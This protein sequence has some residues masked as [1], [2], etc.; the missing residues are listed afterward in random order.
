MCKGNGSFH[1]VNELTDAPY[2]WVAAEFSCPWIPMEEFKAGYT[3]DICYRDMEKKILVNPKR[4]IYPN[5]TRR[6]VITKIEYEWMK[7]H[8]FPCKF[9]TG[10]EWSKEND[11]YKSPFEWMGKVYKKRQEIKDSDK[12]GML[13]YALKIVLN[14]L[15]GKT[16]QS[17][18]GMGKLSNFFFASYIT[19]VTRLQVAEVALKNLSAV[20][21]IAT[22]SVT[23]TKDISAELPIN[24]KLGAWGLDEYTEGLF[25]GSGMRQEWKLNGESVTYARGLTDKRDFNLLEFLKKNRNEDKAWFTRRRPIHLGEM[26]IHY[27][28]LNYEDLG[29]FQS[30]RKRLSVNTDKKQVWE[31]DYDSFGDFLDSKVMGGEYLRV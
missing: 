5:G 13:Q 15:Y 25:I 24:K 20:V 26:L 8:H 3:I 28:V 10:L 11:K 9:I 4:I 22:D 21:E 31:R 6:Q 30:V 17:K 27:K 18:H 2:G 19:A 14:G 23:L 7:A 29:T 12:T 1:W 16:A